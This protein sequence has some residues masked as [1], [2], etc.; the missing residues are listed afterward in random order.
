MKKSFILFAIL[1]LSISVNGQWTE[2]TSGVTTALQSISAVDNNVAW[3]CGDGGVVLRTVNGGTT[4]ENKSG[5]PI[6]AT[7]GLVNI[8]AWDSSNAICTGST[9]TGTFVYRTTNGGTTWTEVLTQTGGFIDAIWMFSATDGIMYG[10]PVGARWSLWKTTN[11][12]ATWDSTGLYLAQ[13]GAEAGWNNAM[14]VNGSTVYFGTNSSRVYYSTNSGTSWTAQ[15]MTLT[16]S[17]GIWFNSPTKGIA[18]GSTQGLVS[19]TNGGTNWNPLTSLGTGTIYAV[20]GYQNVWY[21]TRGIRLFGSTD[22]G[23]T[24]DTVNVAAAG[25]Y[26]NITKARNG[27]VAWACRSN[28]GITKGTNV[29]LPVELT[30]FTANALN[31]QV[32][33]SWTTATEINNRGFE[34]ERKSGNSQFVTI[35]F[36]DGQGTTIEEQSYTYIDSKVD[37]GIY[38]YR[39][40]QIDYDGSFEYSD[41]IEVEVVVGAP[42]EFSLNQNYPNPF[43]PVTNIK[44]SLAEPGNVKLAIYNVLGQQ[45][46]ELVNG[47]K[48][49]GRY[50]LN[51]DASGLPSGAYLYK[52]ESVHFNQV[53]KMLLMK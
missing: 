18:T 29:G 52:I 49:A 17:F 43:N 25:T 53:K 7:T 14:Y 8:F 27:N 13:V 39:L 2:Q 42:I 48:E 19:T 40:K 41:A 5:A 20:T 44:Y 16:N 50:E 33:L 38:S 47:Y 46:K 36:A 35:G 9:A 26:Y 10:D 24:W 23:A 45:V 15:A 51:F 4:W 3:I 6:P 11:G 21:H 30:S 37:P 34:I 28:G 22:D 12:G 31:G 1:F 32:S